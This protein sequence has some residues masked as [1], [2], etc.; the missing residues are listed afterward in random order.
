MNASTNHKI[1]SV[2]DELDVLDLLTLQLRK[3][4]GFSTLSAFTA[5]ADDIRHQRFVPANRADGG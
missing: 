3:A 4:W 2:E 1:L 5:A